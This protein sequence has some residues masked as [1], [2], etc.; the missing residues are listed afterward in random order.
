[1]LIYFEQKV[2]PSL[3]KLEETA[4]IRKKIEVKVDNTETK[5]LVSKSDYCKGYEI[6][7]LD[8]LDSNHKPF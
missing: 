7:F 2:L 3:H 8:P 6:Y 1:M 4:G 5:V